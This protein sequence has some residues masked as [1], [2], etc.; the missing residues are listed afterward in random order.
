MVAFACNRGSGDWRLL[1]Y[2]V[3]SALSAVTGNCGLYIA[4]AQQLGD[5]SE[6]LLIGYQRWGGNVSFHPPLGGLEALD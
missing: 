3:T 2:A 5:D 6:A 1:P 4:G